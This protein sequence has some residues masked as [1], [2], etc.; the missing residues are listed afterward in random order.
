MQF[1]QLHLCCAGRH[2]P[3]PI[4]AGQLPANYRPSRA[5]CKLRAIPGC[6][7]TTGHPGLPARYRLPR[8]CSYATGRPGLAATIGRRPPARHGCSRP[9]ARS[10]LPARY[11]R[12]PA[13]CVLPAGR[14]LPESFGHLRAAG[15]PRAIGE[16]RPS[17]RYR[18]PARYRRAPAICTLPAR[19]AQAAPA[20]TCRKAAWS[21]RWWGPPQGC[22]MRPGNVGSGPRA[23]RLGR[24]HGNGQNPGDFD[25]SLYGEKKKAPNLGA[26]GPPRLIW[27]CWDG[28]G[29]KPGAAGGFFGPYSQAKDQPDGWTAP[30]PRP[31]VLPPAT[32]A[33]K[34]CQAVPAPSG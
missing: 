31:A 13:I 29:G 27:G 19:P 30:P 7:H 21:G 15:H 5:A 33:A 14:A 6:L 28:D 10:R 3:Q 24:L 16:L 11:R 12:A 8:C 1:L 34:V 25:P 9:P 2:S 32:T 22:R 20:G 23:A 4:P 17:A 26:T 18:L